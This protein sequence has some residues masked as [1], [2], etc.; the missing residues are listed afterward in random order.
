MRMLVLGAGL[1]GS[2]CAYDLLQNPAVERVTIADLYVDT[3]PPFLERYHDD[4]RLRLVFADARDREALRTL[5]QGHDACLNALPYFLN[6]PV[7]EEAIDLGLHS[8]DL[9][10]NTGI[11][12]QQLELDGK[13]RDKGVSVIPD[14]GL[15]PGM[16]NIL[17]E[18]GIR[19]LDEPEAVRMFVGGL[20]REPEPPLNYQVVYSLQGVIDYY[21]TPAWVLRDGEPLQIEALSEVEDVRFPAPV[22]T[23]EAFA[24]GGGLSTMPWKYRGRIREAQYKTMRYPGHA[25]IMRAIRELGLLDLRTVHV[26]ETEVVPRDVFISVVEPHLRKPG[27][28]DLVAL[29]VEVE[30]R[31]DGATRR[32]VY[33]CVDFFDAHTGISAMERTTG[34]SLSITGQMQVSGGVNGPGVLT[35][36]DAV[37]GEEY[38]RELAKRGIA[39]SARSE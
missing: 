2:A 29:R 22:G 3:L 35:P 13:A 19:Q 39:I 9:G 20:P 23:L 36:D 31:K 38:V 34:F 30:G 14:S 5:M 15:A 33:E 32:L 27:A 28:E 6:L 18:M 1:Q 12:F 37:P 16:V 17:A 26:R 4:P 21:T 25:Y 24:T 8:C 11:V 7:T 10:G